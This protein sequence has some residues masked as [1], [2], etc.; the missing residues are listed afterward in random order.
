MVGQTRLVLVLGDVTQQDTDAVVNAANS[1][2]LGGGGVDGA[3]NRAGGAELIAAREAWVARHHRLPAGDAVAT[4]AG[5]MPAR[6]VIHTVGPIWQGGR[7]G[8]AE[9]LARAYRSCLRVA[10]AEGLRSVSFPSLSTGAYG[11]PLELAAGVAMAAVREELAASAG[12]FDEVRF[13]LH[14]E[15]SLEAFRGSLVATAQEDMSPTGAPATAPGQEGAHQPKEGTMPVARKIDSFIERSSWIRR[16]FEEG[17]RL[18][19]QYGDD[20]VFDFSLGNPNLEPPAEFDAAVHDLLTNHGPGTHG[21]M[22]NAGY[23][24]TRAAVAAYLTREQGV[25]IPAGNVVMTT[26]A[27]GALN[28]V[29]KAILDEGDEVIV[30]APYF[31]EYDFYTDNHGG[32]LKRVQTT[33]DFDLDVAAIQAAITS[34]TRA[35]LFNSPNNPTGRVYSEAS[36]HEL[37]RLLERE[38][39]ERGRIIYL[40]ADEPYRKIVYDGVQVPSAFAAYPHTLV[41]TSYS[42]DLSLSGE[43]IGFVAAHPAIPEVERLMAGLILANRILGFVNA[44]ALMQRAI[45]RLQGVRVDLASYKRNRDVLHQAL[46]DAG[47]SVPT[48]EGAFYLFPQSPVADDIEFV[49]ELQERLV[50]VVPGTGFHGPGHFRISYCVAPETVDGALPV[51][52]ELGKKYFG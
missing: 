16:M 17:S 42:K 30:P 15:R 35:V 37:G 22:P 28:V 32:V 13:V 6:M 46:V 20:K 38:W 50:L 19:A 23:P 43:R 18:R 4:T 9:T 27:G 48:P 1:G 49:R 47:Y 8:E 21:Y 5:A 2:M 31:V 24:E 40:I 51:F 39:A 41:I 33:P 3:M 25:E 11:Y 14:D 26:G 34:K 44:P 7:A 12:D 29:F 45:T 36:L 10:R 52:A